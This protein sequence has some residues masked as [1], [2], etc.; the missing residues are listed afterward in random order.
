MNTRHIAKHTPRQKGQIKRKTMYTWIVPV[1]ECCGGFK[2]ALRAR[3]G[4]CGGGTLTLRR[5]EYG[6]PTGPVYSARCVHHALLA[7]TTTTTAF[8]SPS[9]P[10]HFLRTSH[11][12]SLV[13][14]PHLQLPP[15][16]PI[17][18]LAP[19]WHICCLDTGFE[20]HPLIRL[21]FWRHHRIRQVS[22][23]SMARWHMCLNS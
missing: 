21:P 12:P 7:F 11:I 20:C 4:L 22:E 6:W 19:F 8:P 1:C 9:P 16:I 18:F 10:C 2:D 17:C 14:L 5:P 23:Y 13:F 3:E 15:Q